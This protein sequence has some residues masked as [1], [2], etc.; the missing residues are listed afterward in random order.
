MSGGY[1]GR[2][3]FVDLTTEKVTETPLDEGLARRF[4][5]GGGLGVRTLCEEQPATIDPLGAENTIGF[6]T[7]P[8]TGTPVPGGARYMAVCKSPLTGGWGESNAGGYFGTELKRAGWDAVF[9]SG[10]A[11][12]PK[13]LLVTDSGLELRDAGHLW[14][15][16]TVETDEALRREVSQ[17]K[18]RIA[19]IGPAGEKMSLISGIS[20]DKG[21]FAARSGVGAVMGAKR[22]K[23]LV[24]KG[25]GGI[26]LANESLVRQL[27]KEFNQG[28]ATSAFAQTMKEHGTC[29]LTVS[30]IAS[31]AAPIKNWLLSGS[32]AFPNAELL[33]GDKII[34]HQAKRYACAGCP[35]ACG[36]TVR[37]EDG[38][39]PVEEVHKPEY[40]TIVG[41]GPLCMNEDLPA[42]IA[43]T[44][45]ANR[46]GI[47]TIS[48]A[49]VIA[50]AMECFEHGILSKKDTDGIELTW[51]NS[52]AMIELLGKMIER[53][54]IGDVLADGVRLAAERIGGGSEDYAMHAGGQEPGFHSA[55][56]LPGRAT[57]YVVDPT[58]GRHT[59][60]SPL[61]CADTNMT[62]APYPELHL[63][64]YE[65]YDFE[66]KGPAQAMMSSYFHFASSAGLCSFS[67]IFTRNLLLVDFLNAVTGWDADMDEVLETGRRIQTLR[68]LFNIR[69]GIKPNEVRL[70]GR[71]AGVPPQ[72]DGPLRGITLDMQALTTGY[73]KAMGWDPDSGRP[74]PE[75]LEQLGLQGLAN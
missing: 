36:G 72:T 53:E 8:L 29:G 56:L 11:A 25:Q 19:C 70:P 59:H 26:A 61:A 2:I 41:F 1:A 21:R 55:L 22:L 51:G 52:K 4:V 34:E 74:S 47:D 68:Q 23:A 6:V 18:A 43:M 44:D 9:V 66:T 24:V 54:G 67:F 5:G 71:M 40:E 32:Q 42:I 35:I 33:H 49:N 57:G 48:A 64:G 3:G 58:P 30:S 63:D 7:G 28:L 60:G 75:T 27:R 15:Q 10:A 13:Y 46:G 31:G 14:G 38:P 16:D 69:E 65:R 73:R 17:P 62:A 45:L 20:S 50:F 39:Y 12:T 37:V